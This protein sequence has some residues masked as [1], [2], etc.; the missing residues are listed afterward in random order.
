MI[1]NNSRCDE[2]KTPVIL[3]SDLVYV[4]I[5]NPSFGP[6]HVVILP[7]KH[8]ESLQTCTKSER[9]EMD[10]LTVALIETYKNNFSFS[11]FVIWE[12]DGINRSVSHYH[13]HIIPNNGKEPYPVIINKI[14]ELKEN[15]IKNYTKELKKIL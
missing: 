8:K 9:Q 6:Y 13:R 14:I 11:D 15:E 1:C 3:E 4:R 2:P 7:K 12:N 5:S 10:D